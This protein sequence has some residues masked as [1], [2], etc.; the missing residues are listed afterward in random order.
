VQA[1]Q[2]NVTNYITS[3]C[4]NDELIHCWNCVKVLLSLTVIWS[5]PDHLNNRFTPTHTDKAWTATEIL[6]RISP[7]HTETQKLCDVCAVKR[8]M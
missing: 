3:M 4:Q 7:P 1:K 2:T 6:P 8:L 5:H